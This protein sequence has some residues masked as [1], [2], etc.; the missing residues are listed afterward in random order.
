MTEASL[1]PE[2][3]SFFRDAIFMLML[4]FAVIM[5]GGWLGKFINGLLS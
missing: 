3:A 1:I 4:C 2:A 5:I